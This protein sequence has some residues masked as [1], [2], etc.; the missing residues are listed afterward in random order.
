MKTFLEKL[1]VFQDLSTDEFLVD[2]LTTDLS[3]ASFKSRALKLAEDDGITGEI[4][5][6]FLMNKIIEQDNI[7]TRL[8]S[9]GTSP[10]LSL[11]KALEND[12]QVLHQIC[13]YLKSAVKQDMFY[14]SY[15]PSVANDISKPL[16]IL[17]VICSDK[18]PLEKTQALQQFYYS[19]SYGLMAKYQAFIWR[20]TNGLQG[21]KSRNEHGLDALIGYESQKDLLRSNTESFL[22]GN[23]ANNVLLYGERGTGKSS[24]IKALTKEYAQQG[25][26]LVEIGRKEFNYLPEIM[27][28]LSNY[29]CKFILVLDDLSFEGNEVE[30]KQLKSYIDGALEEK[31][32]NVLI[33]ATSNRRNLINEKWSEQTGDEMH[34]RDSINERISLADRFGLKIFYPAPNQDEYLQIVEGLAEKMLPNDELSVDELHQEAI[35]WERSASGRSG[36]TAKSF[37]LSYRKTT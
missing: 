16:A 23:P 28:E 25:L 33:Y 6:I 32:E 35:K 24:S 17:E 8:A 2:M 29:G 7:F 12:W 9:K 34:V 1:L 18:T 27:L 14:N 3:N 36:R 10:G 31:P 21:V 13:I 15:Q 19:N 26:R 37:I 30:Y 11:L 4:L 22:A 20:K 5:L